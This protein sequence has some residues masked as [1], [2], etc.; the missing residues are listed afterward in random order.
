M[1]TQTT[2]IGFI[3][4]GRMGTPMAHNLLKAGHSV[5]VYDLV[6]EKVKD[7]VDLGAQA[8]TSP[9]DA[10]KGVEVVISMVLDDK[11]LEVVA[12]GADGIFST[13]APGLIYA[14]MSTVSPMVSEQVADEARKRDI[15]FLQAKVSGSVKPATEGTLTIFASGPEPAYQQC[16]AIFQAM[17]ERLYYVGQG[18]EA[19]YLKLVHSIIVGLT[20]AMIGEAFTFGEKGDVNWSQMIDVINNSPLNST[21]FDYKVPLLKNRDYVHPQSTIN[22]AAKDVDMALAVGKEMNI[23]LPFT[24]LARELMRSMQARGN[25]DLDLIGLVTLM[26]ELAGIEL[27]Q[28]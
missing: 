16:M 18:E 19:V 26:E 21:F 20:T 13:A 4:L 9:A 28:E 10:A 22:V 17:G 3:G 7:I 12:M 24:A 11:A 15:Q 1:N 27:D 5:K 8:A 2:A 25:G 6:P 14:D 23:P